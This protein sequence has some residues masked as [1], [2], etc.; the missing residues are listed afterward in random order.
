MRNCCCSKTVLCTLAKF[1]M[2]FGWPPCIDI[3]YTLDSASV[4]QK[5]K[6]KISAVSLHNNRRQPYL[7]FPLRFCSFPPYK[8][9]KLSWSV[10]ILWKRPVLATRL[11]FSPAHSVGRHLVYMRYLC[12][13]GITYQYVFHPMI[14]AYT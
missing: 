10:S 8:I 1:L 14:N 12:H 2:A 4:Y 13:H 6:S 9:Q 7:S 3:S 11:Q 5:V